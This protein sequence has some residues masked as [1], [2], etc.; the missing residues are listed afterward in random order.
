ML[1]HPGKELKEHLNEVKTL[2][3]NIFKSKKNYWSDNENIY[4]LLEIILETH[5]YGKATKYFQEYISDP[6]NYMGSSLLK[7]H[8]ELSAYLGLHRVMKEFE[9]LKLGIIAFTIISTHHGNFINL[10]SANL[11]FSENKNLEKQ[12]ESFD[13]KYFQVDKDRFLNFL[14]TLKGRNFNSQFKKVSLGLEDYILTN[15]LFSILISADK[16]SAI[17]HSQ[18]LKFRTLISDKI[19]YKCLSPD[20]VDIYKRNNFKEN[21]GINDIREQIYTDIEKELKKVDTEQERIFSI[22]VPTGSGKTLSSLNAVLKIIEKLD[23]N[24]KLIYTLPFTSVIDQN[25]SIFKDVLLDDREENS[26]ILLKHHHLSQK[27]YRKS[28]ESKT[29]QISEYLI[30]NWDSQ[31]IVTTF[32]Q[33]LHTIFSNKNRKLKKFHNLSNAVI[34]LDE[35]QSIP[36][37]YWMLV[38]KTLNLI[39]EK[40]NSYIVL[41]TATMPLIFDENKNEIK[42]LVQNKREYFKHFNRI[43]MDKTYLSEKLN[44]EE[45]SEVI[46]KDVRSF[47]KDNF[48]FIFNTIKSSLYIYNFLSEEFDNENVEIIY[49]STNIIPKHRK[50][51]IEKIKSEIKNR[52]KRVLVVSTQM[53]EAGVDIDLERVYRDFA[54]M[55]SLNQSSGRCNRNGL[56]KKGIFKIFRLKDGNNEYS[57]YIYDKALLNK[58]EKVLNNFEDIISEK[59]FFE[60]SKNYF[61]EVNSFKSDDI[62]K[63]LIEELSKLQYAEA[64]N[65]KNAFKLIED[66]FRTVDL[67]IIADEVSRKLYEKYEYIKSN[68]IAYEFKE[69][70]GKIKS[71]FLSYVISVPEKFYPEG[72]E[73]INFIDETLIERVYDSY[74]GF[75]RDQSQEDYI[76]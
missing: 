23:K 59:N 19:N 60:L 21:S 73:G 27:E 54:P 40:L 35:V 1:S 47:N 25:Y 33:L 34:I 22:N 75:K 61:N 49:L 55:D 3:L 10:N 72:T 20:L 36:H 63:N 44:L 17:Y 56:N 62:S 6:N 2:G 50:E 11:T 12:L 29:Y 4:R 48:L 53:V 45:Y 15:Y 24:Y 38:K 52:G 14:K 70:F 18:N 69:E 71:D 58:T 28:D 26:E 30:E 64:F 5:D 74:T 7:A 39:A 13:Y 68:S 31:V 46:K 32:V 65:G 66:K 43:V 16:G 67:F 9:D 42:E 37:K 57:S 41:V 51:R 8:S 76:F